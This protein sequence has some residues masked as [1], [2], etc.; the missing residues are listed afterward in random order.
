[1]KNANKRLMMSIAVLVI[2]IALAATSTFAWMTMD[3]TPQVDNIDVA[4]TVQDGLYV[5]TTG[6]D[7]DYYTRL[8]LTGSVTS[9]LDAITPAV[10]GA[11][12]KFITIPDGSLGVEYDEI[13]EEYVVD[14]EDSTAYAKITLYIRSQSNYNIHIRSLAVTPKDPLGSGQNIDAWRAFTTAGGDPFEVAQGGE[15]PVEAKI[16]NALRVGFASGTTLLKIVNPAAGTGWE[17][18]TYAGFNAAHDYFKTVNAMTTAERTAFD[19]FWASPA[20][21]FDGIQV[22]QTVLGAVSTENRLL[23]G[24][25]VGS[26]TGGLTKITEAGSGQYYSSWSTPVDWYVATLD[27]Y[28]W[29]EGTDP[30]CFNEILKNGA[31]VSFELA[32]DYVAN[33]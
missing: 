10:D 17:A 29:A 22:A 31:S 12:F 14:S 20:A 1:M 28:I 7:G 32:G 3:T 21:A 24:G 15:L 13:E 11:S 30:D 33:T 2:A 6:A 27:V 8:N 25:S 26:A 18:P 19:T 4:I 23:G 16:E 9:G 5:S